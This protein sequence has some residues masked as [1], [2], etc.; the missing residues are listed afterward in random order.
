MNAREAKKLA[1]KNRKEIE[2]R[3]RREAPQ[4]EKE[5]AEREAKIAKLRE[6]AIQVGVDHLKEMVELE[7]KDMVSYGLT[8]ANIN[9][10]TSDIWSRDTGLDKWD[11]LEH[12]AQLLRKDGY[13]VQFRQT[14]EEDH[15]GPGLF[16]FVVFWGGKHSGE[17]GKN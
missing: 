5:T 13:L 16:D 7:I 15:E 1:L 4:R 17:D 11:L 2:E 3:E 8:T 12:Y 10:S 6:D 14:V 9:I